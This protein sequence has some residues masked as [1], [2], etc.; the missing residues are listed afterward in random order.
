MSVELTT[1]VLQPHGTAAEWAAANPILPVGVIGIESDTRQVKFGDGTTQWNA[2]AYL[3]VAAEGEIETL[4]NLADG[5]SYKRIQAAKA[6][7]INDETRLPTAAGTTVANNIGAQTGATTLAK[8]QTLISSIDNIADGT[9]YARILKDRAIVLN[10]PPPSALW[11]YTKAVK[12]PP[13]YLREIVE[14]ASNGAA[15]VLYDDLGFPSMMYVLRGPILAGHIHPDMG[16]TTLGTDEFPAFNVNNV[17]KNE[18]FISMFK[19]T[20]FNGTSYHGSGTG[21][22]AVSWPGL[23]PTGSLDYDV[24]KTLHTS[25]GPGWHMMNIWERA[26]IMWLSMK[27]NTEPR[28]NTSYGRS[29]ESGYEYECA[30]RSDGLAPGTASGTAKH[31]NGSGPSTWSHNRE[32]WGIHDLVGS[33]YEWTDLMKTIDGLIYMPNDN[34]FDLAEAS[35]PSQGVYID[36]TVAGSGGAP[37]LNTSRENALTDPNYTYTTHSSLAM[38]A[39]YN[40]LDLI[41]RQR[42]LQTGIAHKIAS[43]GTNPWSPKGTLIM[44]NY[45]ERLP[46]CGGYWDNSSHAGLASLFL[47]YP[48]STEYYGAGSRSCYIA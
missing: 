3:H 42:M 37:I 21:W 48:R 26:L 6:D 36:N 9:N 35:W 33:M 18:I 45:G 22:R 25:K 13:D 43:A 19:M 40:A 34:Y 39:E 4:D 12:M 14:T 38:T 23:Y 1:L 24:N 2:L 16:G 27:M 15:T 7:T 17:V 32:R 28:G 41:V 11:D 10:A 8:L 31:R 46:R 29:H 5:T 30:V 47:E 20:S 44:R